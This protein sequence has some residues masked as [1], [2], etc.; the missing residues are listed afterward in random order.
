MLEERFCEGY[1]GFFFGGLCANFPLL[2]NC[3]WRAETRGKWQLTAD[4]SWPQSP[5]QTFSYVTPCEFQW[6]TPFSFSLTYLMDRWE[7]YA[8]EVST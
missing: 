3:D 4:I 8:L 1:V 2:R 7:T 6:V 5:P